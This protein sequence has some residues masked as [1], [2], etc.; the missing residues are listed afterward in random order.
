MFFAVVNKMTDLM[1]SQVEWGCS[2]GM[3]SSQLGK[4][5]V[6][7][8]D[9]NFD[10]LSCSRYGLSWE[11]SLYETEVSE[12]T[13]REVCNIFNTLSAVRDTWPF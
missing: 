3:T 11:D 6:S 4:V 13:G 10:S 12:E 7:V 2:H 1:D 9:G 8:E 5:L